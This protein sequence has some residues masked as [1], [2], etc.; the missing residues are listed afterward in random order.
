MNTSSKTRK[1]VRILVD[2]YDSNR[3]DYPWRKTKD[4]YSILIAELMLQRTKADQVVPTYKKFLTKYPDPQS[5]AKASLSDIRKEIKSLGLNKR[6]FVFKRL[7]KDLVKKFDGKVPSEREELLELFGVGDYVANAMM[8]HS[9]GKMV[10]TVD[11][12]FARVLKRVFSIKVKEPAQKDKKIWK[13][14]ESLMPFSGSKSS[15]FNLAIIDIG[16]NIC[17]PRRPKCQIC[18]LRNICDYYLSS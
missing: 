10:P 16:G 4:A 8:C 9:F 5:L 18:P 11:A 13:F 15:Q 7:G 14:A 17:T 12:N 2:W 1:F 6:A 3:R